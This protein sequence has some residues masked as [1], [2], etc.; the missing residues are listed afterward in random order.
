MQFFFT[1]LFNCRY[2]DRCTQVFPYENSVGFNIMHNEKNH[3][4]KH[5]SGDVAKWAD[6]VNMSCDAPETGHKFWI[7]EQGN[8]TNQGPAAQLT[9]LNHTLRKEASELL[10]EAT[11]GMF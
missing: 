4:T 10:C 7:K 8:C 9:I 5:G 11:D 2:F 6:I 1:K 3:S